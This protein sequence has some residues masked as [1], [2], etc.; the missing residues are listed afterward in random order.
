MSQVGVQISKDNPFLPGGMGPVGR[1]NPQ[2]ED[3]NPASAVIARL[4]EKADAAI[5]GNFGGGTTGSDGT[6]GNAGGTGGA[7]TNGGNGAN[8]S[9]VSALQAAVSNLQKIVGTT[10]PG[11][12]ATLQQKINGA[13]ISAECNQDG[14]ITVTLNWGT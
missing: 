6:D 11:S 4:K 13:T 2:L 5:L 7:G 10:N 12:G 8:G 14:T 9:S 3:C 1:R